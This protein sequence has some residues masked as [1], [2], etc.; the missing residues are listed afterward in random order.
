M[1]PSG[2]D[3]PLVTVK[4]TAVRFSK[5]TGTGCTF[6]GVVHPWGTVTS[7]VV[8]QNNFIELL[9]LLMPRSSGQRDQRAFASGGIFDGFLMRE[10]GISLVALHSKD[11]RA[12]HAAVTARG[13]RARDSSTS[14]A[15]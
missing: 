3:H 7:L 11:V 12:D 10:E 8:F 15:P 14:G 13:I 2:I 6:G 4:K 9:V 5:I 1:S